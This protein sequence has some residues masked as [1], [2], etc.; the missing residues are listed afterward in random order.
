[1]CPPF[2]EET[3]AQRA[4]FMSSITQLDVVELGLEPMS[5]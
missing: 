1:L 5:V 4:Y 2:P 3:K